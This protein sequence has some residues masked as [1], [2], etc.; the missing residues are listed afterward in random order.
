MAGLASLAS[1]VGSF[2][3]EKKTLAYLVT[4]DRKDDSP[5]SASAFQYFPESLS[6]SKAVSWQTKEVPGGSLPLYQWT[7]SGERSISFTAQFS[8]DVDPFPAVNEAGA[9]GLSAAGDTALAEAYK[10]RLK[11]N[12][13]ADRNIDVRSA[14]IWLRQFMLPTYQSGK[15][16]PPPKLMLYLPKS[17][18]GLA[19]G[20]TN[21]LS[22]D[23][24]VCVMTQCEV[25]WEKFFPS[26]NVRLA[27]VQLGFAQI[28]QYKGVVQFPQADAGMNAVVTATKNYNGTLF[29][30][31]DAFL[32]VNADAVKK[33]VLGT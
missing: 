8:T 1:K 23:S 21:L 7:A 19:G 10:T 11:S 22:A 32:K 16:L 30:G 2:L 5:T 17:G 3:S 20:S 33:N 12:G 27:S 25:T 31:Y 14:I 26:G 13:V 18:I 9:T 15:T 6:D 24:I 28:P 4:L 29:L